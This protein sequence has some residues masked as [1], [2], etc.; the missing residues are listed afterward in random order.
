MARFEFAQILLAGRC[1]LRC[2]ACIGRGLPPSMTVPS[3]DRFPLPGLSRFVG[4]LRAAGVTEVSLT[5]SNAEPQLYPYQAE[6]LAYLRRR[7]PGVRVSLHTNGTLALARPAIFNLYDRASISLPSFE[8][9]TYARLTGGGRPIDL[10]RITLMA[11]IP[12]KISTLIAHE[13]RHEIP[14]II[15]RCRALGLRRLVLRWP[16]GNRRRDDLFPGRAPVRTFGGNPV[17]DLQGMEVTVWSFDQSSIRC[18]NL[19]SDGSLVAEYQLSEV[20]RAA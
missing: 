6:L 4:E 20:A 17:Y 18:L 15:E 13:N 14:G 3:L 19:L 12:L 9:E 5:G 1:N 8:P 2:P 16:N 10:A 11:R 7:I